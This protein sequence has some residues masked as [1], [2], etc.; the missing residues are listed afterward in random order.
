MNRLTLI[1]FLAS[2]I[3]GAVSHA[4]EDE[5]HAGHHPGADQN[6]VAPE[7]EDKAAGMKMEK[8]QEAMHEKMKKMQEQ[9]DKIRS[10]RDP[11]ERQKLMKE[12]M[13]SMREGM[14]MMK[15]TGVGMKMGT[16]GKKKGAAEHEHAQDGAAS[17]GGDEMAMME[18][19]KGGGMMMKKHKMMEARMDLLQ[20]M[21]EQMLE[22]ESAEQE[23]ER[24]R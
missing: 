20:K 16:E 9:M 14:K 21:M 2:L 4:A 15:D 6:Q 22:H 11:Q 13:Q 18:G 3:A 12:H 10:S 1:F 17:Q 5:E 24:G 7:P 8:K 23:I 19:M